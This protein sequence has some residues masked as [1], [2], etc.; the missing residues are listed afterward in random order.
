MQ[1]RAELMERTDELFAWMAAGELDVR[2]DKTFPFS[3]APDAHRYLEGRESKGKI[4][5]LP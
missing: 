1:D 2:V 4:L 5:L 3:Q